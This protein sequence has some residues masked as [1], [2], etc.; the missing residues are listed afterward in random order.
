MRVTGYAV[1]AL[2]L[3]IAVYVV[4]ANLIVSIRPGDMAGPI[5]GTPDGGPMYWFAL[6]PAVGAL[7]LGLWLV[8]NGREYRETYDPRRQQT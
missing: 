6:I 2:G 4:A 8:Y 5:Q 3:I 1:M 7:L